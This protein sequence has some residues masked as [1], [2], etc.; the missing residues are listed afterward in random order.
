MDT[1]TDTARGT[2]PLTAALRFELRSLAVRTACS[3]RAIDDVLL[4]NINMRAHRE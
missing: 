3:C 4:I 1:P 2:E